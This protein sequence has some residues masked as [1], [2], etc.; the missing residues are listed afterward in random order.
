MIINC[1]I[2]SQ[3]SIWASKFSLVLHEALGTIFGVATP[4]YQRIIDTDRDLRNF[5]IPKH[6][7]ICPSETNTPKVRGLQQGYVLGLKEIGTH[8]DLFALP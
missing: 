8:F 5:E 3:V 7:K 6:L 4:T 2:Q 1:L